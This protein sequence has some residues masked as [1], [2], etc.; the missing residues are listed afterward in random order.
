MIWE[1][2][3]IRDMLAPFKGRCFMVFHPAWGYFAEEYGLEQVPIEVEGK[4]PGP[5]ALARLIDEA[6]KENIQV[7][8]VQKQFSSRAAETIAKAIHG[9]VVALDPLA[10]DYLDNLIAM[11]ESLVEAWE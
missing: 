7:I 4:E 9:K 8:F 11:A 5:Q 10:E 1:D 3:K 6:R 2:K